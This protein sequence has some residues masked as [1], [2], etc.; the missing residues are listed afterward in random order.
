MYYYMRGPAYRAAPR[1]VACAGQARS[2]ANRHAS[3][4]Y[5]ATPLAGYFQAL[6][7]DPDE[8]STALLPH[9]GV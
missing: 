4:P 1:P 3:V 2:C 5:M 8:E 9:V 7:S 6:A